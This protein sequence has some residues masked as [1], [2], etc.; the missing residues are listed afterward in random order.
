MA[1]PPKRAAAPIAPVWIAAPAVEVDVTVSPAE[2]VVV[3]TEPAEVA[4]L[5]AEEDKEEV[6]ELKLDARELET[7]AREDEAEEA[8]EPVRVAAEA[9]AAEREDSAEAWAELMEDSAE[10]TTEEIEE[11]TEERVD[12]RPDAR[13]AEDSEAEEAE[14]AD[15]TAALDAAL[16]AE[17]VAEL[18]RVPALAVASERMDST[19][20]WP[21][22][23]MLASLYMYIL[24]KWSID[25]LNLY[26]K[27][28]GHT[29][30]NG[31]GQSQNNNV[32]ELHIDGWLN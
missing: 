8:A 23:I 17:S 26:L 32:L 1:A 2:L 22:D 16:D 20:D 21:Y 7:D 9:W 4:R 11:E 6:L 29:Y 10:E 25:S 5:L 31:T 24:L 30:H 19:E 13:E 18:R 27:D 15:V 12:E 3:T 14:E 28:E